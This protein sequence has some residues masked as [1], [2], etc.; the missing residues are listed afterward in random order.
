[1]KSKESRRIVPIS[2]VTLMVL[3]VLFVFEALVI[4]GAVELKASRVARVAPWAYE[5]FLRLVGE[6]PDSYRHRNDAGNDAAEPQPRTVL[7]EI[8]GVEEDLLQADTN[9]VPAEQE[10]ME[11]NEPGPIGPEQDASPELPDEDEPVG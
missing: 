9:T 1:M 5:P 3:A 2:A 7:E 11:P 10:A 4:A 8:T 6:H